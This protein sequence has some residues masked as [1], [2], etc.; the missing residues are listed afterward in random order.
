MNFVEYNG[1]KVLPNKEVWY[2][3][4][5]LSKSWCL[6]RCVEIS[7]FDFLLERW[8][9]L[10]LVHNNL[11]LTCR[12]PKTPSTFSIVSHT[13]FL[14]PI[15]KMALWL[16]CGLTIS[17]SSAGA[18]VISFLLFMLL[19]RPKKKWTRVE[20]YIKIGCI[21]MFQFLYIVDPGTIKYQSFRSCIVLRH[22]REKTSCWNKRALHFPPAWKRLQKFFHEWNVTS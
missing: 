11:I 5:K 16:F 6:Y 10:E 19:I 3:S 17:C 20:I 12:L 13:A 18:T 2:F 7:R 22:N 21:N 1:E 4:R 14:A 8:T 15:S 9:K